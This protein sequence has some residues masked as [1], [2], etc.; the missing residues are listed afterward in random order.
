MRR[1]IARPQGHREVISL[2]DVVSPRRDSVL[3][4]VR[5]VLFE[6]RVQIVHVESI[7]QEDKLIERFHVVEFDGAPLDRRRSAIVR[8]AVRAAIKAA[9][10]A[11]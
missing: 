4:S 9:E 3:E 5:R 1:L 11:A 2:L 6:H 8:S 7:V 10:T